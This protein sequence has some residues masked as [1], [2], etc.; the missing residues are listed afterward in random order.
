[1]PPSES[2]KPSPAAVPA[3]RH[4]RARRVGRWRWAAAI[5]LTLG[6][7]FLLAGFTRVD[8]DPSPRRDALNPR[9]AWVGDRVLLAEDSLQGQQLKMF[10][11]T[12]LFLVTQ[13]NFAGSERSGDAGGLPGEI[14]PSFGPV[15]TMPTD[16]SPPGLVTAPVDRVN[17]VIAVQSFRWPYFDRFGR[18]DPVERRFEAR[19]ARVEVRS[20][21]SG[22]EVLAESLPV[23][24]DRE[25][26]T[27]W[28]DWRPFE[29]FITVSETGRVSEPLLVGGG[30]GSDNVDRYMRDHIRR[31]M[32]LDLR[33]EPGNYRIAVGP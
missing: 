19:R 18:S 1:M 6:F 8:L 13:E 33:L 23:E 17:P 7:H 21:A 2:P 29:V 11:D 26:P 31:R 22:E 20:V 30:S 12:P 10:D 27:V 16:R 14:F 4:R 28:P 3:S 32:R 25:A 15:L 9:V 24:V 5:T